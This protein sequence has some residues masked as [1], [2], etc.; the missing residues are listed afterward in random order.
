M[1][2]AEPAASTTRR[3]GRPRRSLARSRASRAGRAARSSCTARACSAARSS[4]ARS[5]AANRARPRSSSPPPASDA[6]IS[7]NPGGGLAA[8]WTDDKGVAAQHIGRRDH[9]DAAAAHHRRAVR[10][11]DRR[12]VA[13]R[14]GRRRRLR[15]VRRERLRRRE[16]RPDRHVGV[17]HPAGDRPA[18]ARPAAGRRHRLADGRPARHLD[19]HDGEVRRRHGRGRRPAASP[20]TR[21]P[22]TSTSRSAPSTS[23]GFRSSPT[24]A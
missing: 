14:D 23:T 8:A 19:L 3:C 7:E 2:G 21:A 22:P 11:P 12:P 16:R 13:R 4:C 9:L 17:R 6:T 10:R 18:R 15:D 20:T 1:S 5:S 24:P